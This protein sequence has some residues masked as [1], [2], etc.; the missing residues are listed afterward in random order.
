MAQ[1]MLEHYPWIPVIQ[2]IEYYGKPYASQQLEIRSFNFRF[3]RT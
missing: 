1:I 2:P 3:R